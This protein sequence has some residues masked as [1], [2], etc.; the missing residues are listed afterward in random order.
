MTD[1][2]ADK[3][4]QTTIEIIDSVNDPV[5]GGLAIGPTSNGTKHIMAS[6]AG[7]SSV[8]SITELKSEVAWLLAIETED[9]KRIGFGQAENW[10]EATLWVSGQQYWVTAQ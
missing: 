10:P 4:A 7:I 3:I 9:G 6:I 5:G 8:V 2:Q 1:N